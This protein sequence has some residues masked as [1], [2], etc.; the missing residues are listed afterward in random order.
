MSPCQC[1]DPC[2]LLELL[3]GRQAGQ[4]AAARLR[5]MLAES[6]RLLPLPALD[7]RGIVEPDSGL[8]LQDI[9]PP[10]PG[11][12]KDADLLLEMVKTLQAQA[13]QGARILRLRGIGQMWGE[14]AHQPQDLLL[15]SFL[16]AVLQIAAPQALLAAVVVGPPEMRSLYFGNGWNAAHLIET[17][18]LPNL[19]RGAFSGRHSRALQAW[20]N[21]LHLP[22][23]EISYLHDGNLPVAADWA[24][25]A[26][27]ILLALIGVPVLHTRAA[28]LPGLTAL[29]H[30][31]TTCTAF[32]PWGAQVGLPCGESCLGLMRIAPDGTIAVCFTNV[33]PLPQTLALDASAL[34]FSAAWQDLFS[35]E[36]VNLNGEDWRKLAPYQSRWW[37]SRPT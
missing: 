14:E 12:F 29:L 37:V 25:A 15:L 33:S 2:Q 20:V 17:S 23:T 22:V 4:A 18:E 27:A 7:E 1:S 3:Y 11:N 8:L 10:Q 26:H 30:A 19:L 13:Q 36:G 24:L 6:F 16:R 28:A 9:L 21:A 35:G 34:G 5:G 32:S 31:R